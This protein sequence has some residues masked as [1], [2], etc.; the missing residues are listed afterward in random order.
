MIKFH[1]AHVLRSAQAPMRTPFFAAGLAF[2]PAAIIAR[3]HYDC[4]TPMLF[5]G[6]EFSFT[7]RLYT[8]GYDLYAPFT[9][10]VYHIYET[11]ANPKYWQVDWEH[12]FPIRQRAEQRVLHMLGM[13]PVHGT[14]DEINTTRLDEFS[15]GTERP[16]A[17]LLDMLNFDYAHRENLRPVARPFATQAEGAI[18][19]TTICEDLAAGKWPPFDDYRAFAHAPAA[20]VWRRNIRDVLVKRKSG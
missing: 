18:F 20:E 5:D 12:R 15:L 14:V 9:D 10:P 2:A 3:V 7:A 11:G 16:L 17:D 8:H 13:D 19:A 1:G 6:E 4:C